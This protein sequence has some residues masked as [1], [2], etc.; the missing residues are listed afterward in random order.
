MQILVR[1]I[2]I[3]T[4]EIK[5]ALFYVLFWILAAFAEFYIIHVDIYLDINHGVFIFSREKS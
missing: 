2:F 1:V 5:N 3:L 4:N